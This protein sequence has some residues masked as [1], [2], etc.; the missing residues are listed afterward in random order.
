MAV[1]D[2]TLDVPADLAAFWAARLADLP[3]SPE[4]SVRRWAD[5]RLHG[6]TVLDVSYSS[7]GGARINA[8]LLYPDGPTPLPGYVHYPGYSAGRDSPLDHLAAA[9][10]GF[11]V[12]AV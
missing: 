8:W 9:V 4:L 7:V 6:V 12:L 1:A 11:V 3:A 2:L 10:A 5:I